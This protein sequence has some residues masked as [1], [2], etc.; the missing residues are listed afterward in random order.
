MS[1]TI[2]LIAL[3]KTDIVGM[4]N[5][6]IYDRLLTLNEREADS[7]IVIVGIDDSSLEMLGIWPWSRQTHADFLQQLKKYKPKA[8]LFDVLTLEPSTNPMD[9]QHLGEA[10]GQFDRIAAPVSLFSYAG[11]PIGVTMPIGSVARNASLGQIVQTPD[12]DG[13]VRQTAL[14]IKDK[15]GTSWPLLTSLLIDKA[16]RDESNALFRIPFNVPKGRYVTL[17]YWS[18]LNHQVPEGFLQDKY[19]L[20]GATA[21]GLGDQRVTP[22]SG[23]KGTV[24]GIEIHANILDTLLNDLKIK[25]LEQPLLKQLNVVMPLIALMLFFYGQVSDFIYLLSL[26]LWLCIFHL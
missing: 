25:N 1:L 9:D 8:V 19:V 7:R 16:N 10:M 2:V 13:V 26:L 12:S 20:I 14:N 21:Q 6:Y 11:E 3:S 4:T 22:V 24:A 5:N 17:P 23:E 15:N 18:V